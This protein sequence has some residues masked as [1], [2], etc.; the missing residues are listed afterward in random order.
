MAE[1][2]VAFKLIH[3]GVFFSHTLDNNTLKQVASKKCLLY[4]LT[5]NGWLAA[6]N[7]ARLVIF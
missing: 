7:G 1:D 4:C 2:A 5:S 3:T 6:I